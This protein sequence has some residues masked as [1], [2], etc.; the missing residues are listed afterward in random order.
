M[1]ARKIERRPPMLTGDAAQDTELLSQYLEEV[2]EELNFILTLI[3]KQLG[4]G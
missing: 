1:K 3:Y 2:I 4:E